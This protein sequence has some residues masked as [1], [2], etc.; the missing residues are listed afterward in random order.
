MRDNNAKNQKLK[1]RIADGRTGHTSGLN[2]IKTF[3]EGSS[4]MV[5]PRTTLTK[6]RTGTHLGSAGLSK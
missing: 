2:R 4:L 6:I 3:A 5:S 1:C